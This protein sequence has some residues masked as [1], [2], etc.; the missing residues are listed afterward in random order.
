MNSV[1][2]LAEDKRAEQESFEADLIAGRLQEDVVG[3]LQQGVIANISLSRVFFF[4]HKQV[5]NIYVNLSHGFPNC[6][7][8]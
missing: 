5:M 6:F 4:Q 8:S 1:L 3:P 7:V 2:S